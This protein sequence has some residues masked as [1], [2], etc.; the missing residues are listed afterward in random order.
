MITCADTVRPWCV[1]AT[2]AGRGGLSSG[3][4]MIMPG[5]RA[6]TLVALATLG[7]WASE[8]ADGAADSKVVVLTK[9]SFPAFVNEQALSLVEFYAPWCGHCQALA[10]QYEIAAK[11]L[12]SENIKLAKVD[13]TQE[14]ALC[15]EQGIS[16]FP[17][18]KVFRH[19]S[20]TP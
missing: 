1:G 8:G 11:E 13:C 5:I 19:G 15:G 14:E 9:D 12:V 16:G 17:T 10:P 7:V 6:W 3:S 18:L 2:V 20:A 4:T